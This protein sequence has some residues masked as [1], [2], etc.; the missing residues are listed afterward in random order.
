M[1][2][3]VC[4]HERQ[5]LQI[6]AVEIAALFGS[7]AQHL[8]GLVDLFLRRWKPGRVRHVRPSYRA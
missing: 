4:T 6:L 1:G 5:R 7:D 3:A 8:A 2:C